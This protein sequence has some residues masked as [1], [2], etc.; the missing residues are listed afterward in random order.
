MPEAAQ[1]AEAQQQ[2]WMERA[3]GFW[4][5]RG[6]S[7]TAVRRVICKAIA[8]QEATFDAE[9][10]L[11]HCRRH[12]GLI[13]LSTVYRTLKHLVEGD[14]LVELEGI[15][16]KRHFC[17]KLGLDISDSTVVCLDCKEVIPMNNPCLT[18]RESEEVK[19]MGFTPKR[20]SLRVETSCDEWQRN[21]S[22]SRRKAR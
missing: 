13:S 15:D 18:L 4:R 14:L 1:Y 6:S 16:D 2:L 20:L 11:E 21:G 19:R 10:L 9:M 5:R 7:M 12:D 17:L 8:E 3:Q 22:C